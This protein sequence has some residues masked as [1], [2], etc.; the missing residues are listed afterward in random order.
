MLT[1]V[2]APRVVVVARLAPLLPS[3]QVKVG[4]LPVLYPDPADVTVTDCTT[5]PLTEHV[6]AAPYPCKG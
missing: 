3:G 5:P 6:P 2:T 4:G 1:L